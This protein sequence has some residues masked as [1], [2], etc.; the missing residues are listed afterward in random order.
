MSEPFDTFYDGAAR[1][2]LVTVDDEGW[3]RTGDGASARRSERDVLTWCR[4]SRDDVAVLEPEQ[5]SDPAERTLDL[6]AA[7]A[8]RRARD[9]A[10][11]PGQRIETAAA[12]IKQ[13]QKL[14]PPDARRAR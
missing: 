11:T 3:K 14:V 10:L 8:V 5:H 9:A 2:V 1:Y 4:W 12:L 13:A 6:D 7:S